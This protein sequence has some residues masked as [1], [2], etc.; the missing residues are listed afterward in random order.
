MMRISGKT[1]STSLLTTPE[2]TTTETVIRQD[3]DGVNNLAIT[4]LQE[5]VETPE[6]TSKWDNCQ[7]YSTPVGSISVI[8]K[9]TIGHDVDGDTVLNSNKTLVLGR[10]YTVAFNQTTSNSTHFLGHYSTVLTFTPEIEAGTYNKCEIVYNTN[11][12]DIEL[13]QTPLSVDDF[14]LYIDGR[15]I[16]NDDVYTLDIHNKN[17]VI[18]TS[19]FTTGDSVKLN[20][21]YNKVQSNG[22]YSVDFETLFGGNVYKETTVE[23]KVTSDDREIIITKPSTKK[24]SSEELPLSYKASNYPTLGQLVDAINSDS[25]NGFVKAFVNSVHEAVDTLKLAAKSETLFTAADDCNEIKLSKQK[26]FHK[27]AGKRD[28]QGYLTEIGAFQVL[29]NYMVDIIV[30]LGCFADDVLLG[31]YDNFAYEL[32][33]LC[34]KVSQVHL[35]HGVISVKS[36]VKNDLVTIEARVKELEAMTNIFEMRRLDGSVLKDMDNKAYDLGGY[37]SIIAGQELT[38][39]TQKG[40]IYNDNATLAYAGL[41]STV[42]TPDNTTNKKMDSIVGMRYSYSIPQLNR[43]QNKRFVTFR[44]RASDGSIVVTDGVTAAKEGSDY[45]RLVNTNVVRAILNDVHKATEPYIGLA[46][47]TVNNNAMASSIDK[48]LKSRQEQGDVQSATFNLVI[49]PLDKLL[50]NASVEL[51]IVPLGETRII[52]IVVGLK[53]S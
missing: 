15:Y 16:L 19:S 6:R 29:D 41:I 20:Y 14:Q 51:N 9:D 38:Y 34:G 50:G 4:T 40:G 23:V 28:T 30:P 33:L 36:P 52:T 25:N 47:S 46:Q 8:M 7:L 22:T 39:N 45:S 43:L 13:E 3:T 12:Q 27:L 49:D 17:V 18:D 5:I 42:N 2:T 26:L 24:S 31:D 53:K 21:I 11:L 37:I 32:A 10:D 48:K 1:V 35:T 44:T